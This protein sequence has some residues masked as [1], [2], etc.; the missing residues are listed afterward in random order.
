MSRRRGWQLGVLVLLGAVGFLLITAAEGSLSLE[1]GAFGA[2]AGAI[3]LLAKGLIDAK[4]GGG[5]SEGAIERRITWQVELT[6]AIRDLRVSM[7]RQA[8][9]FERYVTESQD[10]R[11]NGLEAMEK[12]DGIHDG[13]T[14]LLG[15]APT[16]S[17][18]RRQA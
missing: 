6:A 7:E 18:Q 9:H 3:V 4:R 11:R 17:D 10:Y 15:K 8:E 16:M 5:V 13:V 1:G 2:L 12:I 14:R